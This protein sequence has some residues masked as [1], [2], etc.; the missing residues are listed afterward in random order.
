M[1][2]GMDQRYYLHK[3]LLKVRGEFGLFSP[4]APVSPERPKAAQAATGC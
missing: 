4:L 3:G 2:R 1:K